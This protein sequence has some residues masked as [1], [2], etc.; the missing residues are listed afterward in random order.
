[1]DFFSW[2]SYAGVKSNV[3]YARYAKERL[4]AYGFGDCEVFLNEW[5]PS[6]GSRGNV[7]GDAADVLA[8]MVALQNTPTDMCMYY[9]AAERSGY[10]GIFSPYTHGVTKTYYAFFYFGQMYAMGEQCFADAEGEGL[11][12]M[13][14]K[15]KGKKAFVLVNTSEEER[16]IS[17]D[18]SGADLAMGKVMA[19][20]LEH[21]YDETEPM[22]DALILPPRSVRYVEFE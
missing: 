2:H 9:D 20:D 1:M 5:N 22:R 6:K 13:A 7:P 19:T 8:M 11:Y 4:E 12:V 14:A 10:C 18:V 17:L 16:E 21:T 15:G 3:I